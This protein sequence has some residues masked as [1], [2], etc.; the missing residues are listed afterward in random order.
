VQRA[1]HA[2]QVEAARRALGEGTFIAA[3]AE[4]QALAPQQAV[5]YALEILD[6]ALGTAPLRHRASQRSPAGLTA[7]ELEVLRLVAAG[8]TDSQVASQLTLSRR[9]VSAHL[10]SIYGKLGV[11]SRTAAAHW[12]AEHGLTGPVPPG[13]VDTYMVR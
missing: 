7:R 1:Y 13:P 6:H 2:E 4:G 11:S 9:T 5:A 3:W 10:A 8:L 12:M